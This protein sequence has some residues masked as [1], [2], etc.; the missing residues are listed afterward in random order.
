MYRFRAYECVT[1]PT[2]TG[3][4]SHKHRLRSSVFAPSVHHAEPC[5]TTST[6]KYG[7]TTCALGMTVQSIR[8]LHGN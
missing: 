6:N 1:C 4:S 8:V 2:Y 5:G 3:K 7:T